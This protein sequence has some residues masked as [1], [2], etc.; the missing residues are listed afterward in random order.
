MH[1]FGIG[2]KSP[3]SDPAC[4]DSFGISIVQSLPH[5]AESQHAVKGRLWMCNARSDRISHI[6]SLIIID[7]H[8]II[9]SWLLNAFDV[10]LSFTSYHCRIP[11]LWNANPYHLGSRTGRFG[12]AVAIHALQVSAGCAATA[13]NVVL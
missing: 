2:A 11:S 7:Y 5:V 1:Q 8:S 4:D 9:I 12:V 10:S 3:A 13:F 6:I